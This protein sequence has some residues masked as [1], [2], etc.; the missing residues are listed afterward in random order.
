MKNRN[1]N[2][3]MKSTIY[4]RL[5]AIA[6]AGLL[7]A[8]SATSSGDKQEQ[9]KKL[10][11]ERDELAKKIT[12]LEE[13]IAKTSPDSTKKVRT[14]DVMVTEV[15]AK[16]FEYFVSTQGGV[17]A[18]ENINVSA[19]S[20]GTITQVYVTEG[21]TVSKGQV[22]AQL[23]NS[24]IKANID[25][26]KAQL[27]LATTV[28][29]RQKNL[30]EQKIGS[31]VQFL[32]TKTD[33]E[34]LEKQL[35]AT[36][37]QEDMTKIKAPISGTVDA[38]I[39]KVGEAAAPGQPAFRVVNSSNLKIKANVSEA[40]V[41]DIKKGNKVVVTIPEL[42]KDINATVTFVG[43]TIDQNSRTFVVEIKLPALADLRPNM[44]GVVKVIF[45]SV[46]SA[47]VVPINAVQEVNNQKVVFVAEQD[48]KQ[49]IARKKVI[50]VEAVYGNEAEVKGL[51]AGDRVITFGYQGLNDGQAISI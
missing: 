4:N 31:E 3:T 27:Q 49:M 6:L 30:W 50:T 22:L 17:E 15:V 43:K 24:V 29:E 23:D 12:A 1:N 16:K 46:P 47:I 39:A 33:K 13:E 10:K 25:A 36:L 8:C 38:V 48:G 11:T 20:P 19:K 26:M 34:A 5:F 40:Y 7:V 28:Y 35:S 45:N 9:L 21:Q 44:T 18:E 51:N 42:K 2:L 37:E 32:K 41:T 14:K